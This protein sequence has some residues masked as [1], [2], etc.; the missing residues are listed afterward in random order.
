[1]YPVLTALLEQGD[2]VIMFEPFFDQYLPSVTF[3]GGKLVP[4]DPPR[5]IQGKITSADWTI[6]FNELMSVAISVTD[7]I[8]NNSSSWTCHHTSHED[9]YR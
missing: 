7:V 2:E 8:V 6:D 1:M 3:K 4:L 5:D 9:N